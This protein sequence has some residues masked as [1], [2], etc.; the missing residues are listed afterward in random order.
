MHREDAVAFH[1][2][3]TKAVGTDGGVTSSPEICRESF[4][5]AWSFSRRGCCI[6]CTVRGLYYVNRLMP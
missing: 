2:A 6:Y 5:L 4:A 1:P 3:D